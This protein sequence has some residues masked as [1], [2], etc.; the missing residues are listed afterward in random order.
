MKFIVHVASPVRTYGAAI[1]LISAP[2]ERSVGS[3]WFVRAID[4]AYLL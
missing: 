2:F 3:V 1:L 4:M